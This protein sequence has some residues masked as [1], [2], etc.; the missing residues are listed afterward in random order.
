MLERV[1]DRDIDLPAAWE[2]EWA[3]HAFIAPTT[4][5]EAL[6]GEWEKVRGAFINDARTIEGLETYTNRSWAP[7]YRR[8]TVSSFASMDWA[9]LRMKPGLGLKKLRVLVEMFA[10]AALDGIP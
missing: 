9:D 2:R 8:E 3:D 5:E 10:V 4:N 1:R 7:K 6:A